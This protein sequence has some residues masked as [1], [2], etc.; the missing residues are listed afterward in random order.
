MVEFGLKLEDNKVS[1]WSEHYLDYEALKKVLKKAKK[2]QKNYTEICQQNPIEADAVTKVYHS[3]NKTHVVMSNSLS[4]HNFSTITKSKTGQDKEQKDNSYQQRNDNDKDEEVGTSTEK[5]ALLKDQNI[6]PS[7][8]H[9]SLSKIS[10]QIFSTTTSKESSKN[11]IERKIRNI[12]VDLDEQTQAFEKLFYKQQKKVVSFYYSQLQELQSRLEHVIGSVAQSQGLGQFYDDGNVSEEFG[13]GAA[14]SNN[15]NGKFSSP[16]P[17]HRKQLSS[18]GQ[19]VEELINQITDSVRSENYNEENNNYN[20]G[21]VN[22]KTRRRISNIRMGKIPVRNKNLHNDSNNSS[23]SLQCSEDEEYEDD[24]EWD[25]TRIAEAETIK[26]SLVDQYRVAKLLHNYSMMNITGFVKIIKKF[27]KTIPFEKGKF[28]GSLVTRIMLNDGKAID[29]LCNKYE[30]YYAN[31]FCEGDKIEAKAQ[32]LTK[33]GDGLDMDWSQLQLGYRL[34]MCAILALWIAWDCIWG[35]ISNG[36]STIAARPAF[37]VFRACGGLLLL[38]WFWGGS[39]FM[40]TRYRVNYIFLFDFNPRIVS[41]PV[42]IVKDAVDNTLLYLSLMLL[43]YKAGINEI[44]LWIPPGSYPFILVFATTLNLIFPLK[45]RRPMWISIFKVVTAPCHSP[46]FFQTYVGDIFTSLVKVFQDL[47]W[48]FFWVFT[49][50]FSMNESDTSSRVGHWANHPWYKNAL[51][52]IIT[53]LPLIIRFLQCLRKFTDSGDRLP[54]LANAGKYALSQLVSLVGAFHPLYLELNAEKTHRL[55]VYNIGWTILY[56]VS[57]LYSFVWDVYMDWGLGRKEFG[58]LGPHLMYPKKSLYYCV[59]A[60][61]LVLRSLWL[62]SFVP[63]SMGV[64]FAIPEYLTF[65]QIVLE[66]F[67]RTVWGFFRL[68]NEHRCNVSGY[69]RVDF[70]PLHFQTGHKH[71]YEDKKKKLGS[72][73][74]TELFFIIFILVIFCA[75]CIIAARRATATNLTTALTDDL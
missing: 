4:M 31:W 3:G 10:D 24:P 51:I 39:V 69:R 44:P 71:M 6:K 25:D 22:L 7:L 47:V 43:Y 61:D 2:I 59:I 45:T 36:T 73:V 68:E 27:D 41:T 29:V 55:P 14:D 30:T 32:M 40:W 9:L 13:G 35:L 53:L 42:G 70:V 54:H 38:Q 72:S 21:T 17:K 5:T 58:F 67:R 60:L 62:L 46:T 28:K 48:T 26:M 1:E 20:H 18:M 57:A 65:L 23:I 11:N 64:D 16:F 75:A 52:P 49:G 34:G 37:T 33:R 66:L 8:S 74:L 15:N 56:L 63:P 50:D 19:K 12:L